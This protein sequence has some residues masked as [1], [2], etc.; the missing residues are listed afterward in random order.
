MAF[1]G[2][3]SVKKSVR[4]ETIRALLTDTTIY[5]HYFDV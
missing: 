5:Y 4:I 1:G 2:N 3:A